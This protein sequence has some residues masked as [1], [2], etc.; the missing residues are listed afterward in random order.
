MKNFFDT[1]LWKWILCLIEI[2]LLAGVIILAVKGLGV[3]V[4]EVAG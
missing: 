2:A 4:A 3:F 1:E